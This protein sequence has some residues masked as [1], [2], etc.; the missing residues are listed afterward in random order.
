MKNKLNGN[1][2]LKQEIYDLAFM[3]WDGLGF[4]GF[5]DTKIGR[6]EGKQVRCRDKFT[7]LKTT[8]I[9]AISLIVAIIIIVGEA[10]LWLNGV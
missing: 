1:D 4:F 5:D 2:D 3:M 8:P 10:D 7:S 6:L 9:M